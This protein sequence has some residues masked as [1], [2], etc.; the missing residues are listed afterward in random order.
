MLVDHDPLR[1]M[2][3]LTA[4]IVFT[5]SVQ[6]SNVARLF[7]ESS[8]QL[9]DA[10]ERMSHHLS[11]RHWGYRNWAAMILSEQARWIEKDDLIPY[12]R[13]GTGQAVSS[14]NQNP[15]STTIQHP[16]LSW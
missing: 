10:V 5:G 15:P 8:A 12:G 1:V 14:D 9:A 2:R 7:A 11:D 6:L 13:H 3:E 16:Q 4:G